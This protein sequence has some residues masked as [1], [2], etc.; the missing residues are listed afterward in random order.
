MASFR[1][2]TCIGTVRRVLVVPPDNPDGTIVSVDTGRADVGFE[3]FP[4]ETHSGLTR[5]ACVR[6]QDIYEQG[7]PIR[8]VRQ[9]SIVSAEEMKAVAAG[10]E[11]D[12]IEPEW[13][14]ANLELEGIP[15]F[16]LLPPSTRLLFDGGASLVVDMENLPCAYPAKEIEKIHPGKGKLFVKNAR[17]R[18]GITAWVEKEGAIAAGDRVRVFLPAQPAW[19]HE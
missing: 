14:G 10:M 13:M 6:V 11:I 7:T 18:R 15:D 9:I 4:G 3:G 2:A 8:N 19:P 12:A 1:Q 16:T 5:A 17:R